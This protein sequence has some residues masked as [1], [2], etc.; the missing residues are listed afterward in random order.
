MEY[1]ERL[2]QFEILDEL[3]RRERVIRD[4]TNPFTFYDDFDFLKR[5]RFTKETV[6]L[7]ND[8]LGDTLERR[9]DLGYSIP[10]TIQILVALRFYGTGSFLKVVCF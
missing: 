7:L 8:E 1:L 3:L 2:E 4:R 6:L 10:P 9:K 5:Y